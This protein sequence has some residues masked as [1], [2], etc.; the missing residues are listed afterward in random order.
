MATDGHLRFLELHNQPDRRSH[1][2]QFSITSATQRANLGDGN[3][4]P[5]NIFNA[6]QFNGDARSLIENANGGSGDDRITGKCRQQY[7]CRQCWQ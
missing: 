3:T 4:A 6:L 2:G 5:G 1:A 7:T